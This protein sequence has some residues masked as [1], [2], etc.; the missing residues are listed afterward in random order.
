MLGSH[1]WRLLGGT[2]A[3]WVRSQGYNLGRAR[4]QSSCEIS[5]VTNQLRSGVVWLLS[6]AFP[7]F[8]LSLVGTDWFPSQ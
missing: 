7:S 4:W 1:P 8:Q 2:S 6:L 3:N 5:A